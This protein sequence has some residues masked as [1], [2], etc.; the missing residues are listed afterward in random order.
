MIR[1]YL[2]YGGI[3]SDFHPT[4]KKLAVR[5]HFSPCSCL[6]GA[7]YIQFLYLCIKSCLLKLIYPLCL[8]ES[9]LSSAACCFGVQTLL[10]VHNR[11]IALGGFH[12]WSPQNFRNFGPLPPHCVHKSADFVPLFCF[13]GTPSSPH[14]LRTSYMEAPCFITRGTKKYL[15]HFPSFLTCS[16]YVVITINHRHYNAKSHP[17]FLRTGWRLVVC[18][19]GW[20]D[21]CLGIPQCCMYCSAKSAISPPV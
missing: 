3:L 15:R 14:Q 5:S 12:I 21:F 4:K 17:F 19:M 10:P 13:L 8:P 18:H 1:L 9:T 7:S 2:V 20:V 16:P 6:R 11:Y